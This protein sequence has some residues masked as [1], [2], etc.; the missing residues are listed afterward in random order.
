MDVSSPVGTDRIRRGFTYGIVATVVMSVLMLAGMVTGQSPIPEP[1]PRAIV[2]TLLGDRAPKPVTIALA[3][4]LHL[5]C[6]GVFGAALARFAAPATVAKGLGLG[7]GLWL[8]MG[9]AFLPF[10]GWGAFG[11]AIAPS[12]AVATLLL[13]LVYGATLGWALA[14][15]GPDA[16]GPA[17]STAD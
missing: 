4:G 7:V 15:E 8:V 10:L 1:I 13:H 14:R 16:N 11:T 9:V 12:I 5:A 6:G 17:V 3:V 2:A